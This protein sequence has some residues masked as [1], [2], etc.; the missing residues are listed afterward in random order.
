[1]TPVHFSTGNG[2]RGIS[3]ADFN[4]DTFP[5]LVMA[6]GNLG[7][8]DVSVLIN[9]GNGT[10]QPEQ[11]H[12]VGTMPAFTLQADINN[13]GS[14]DVVVFN[15]SSDDLSILLGQGDGSFQPELRVAI[16]AHLFPVLV[17]LN[18][19]NQLDIVSTR[20]E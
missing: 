16:Q 2:P 6:N 8:N 20:C 12:S 7:A 9:N 5:D 14:P 19:D 13:D 15:G 4:L 11:R 18:G 3:V 1:M 10:F 17:D